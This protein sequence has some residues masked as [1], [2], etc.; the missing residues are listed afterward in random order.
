LIFER[1]TVRRVAPIRAKDIPKLA[2]MAG[3]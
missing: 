3:S 2:K 1:R